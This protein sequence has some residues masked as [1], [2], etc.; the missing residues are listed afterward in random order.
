MKPKLSF[1]KLLR[2][3]FQPVLDKIADFLAARGITAN[4][5]T[6]IGLGGTIAAA[7]LI[8]LGRHFWGG[9]LLAMMAPLDAIDGTLARRTGQIGPFGAFLDSTID[10]Y[11]EWLIFGA[12]TL[13]Y[14]QNN[15][16]P[17]LIISLIALG[18]A[19]LV[20]YTRARAEALG[21]NAK[22]GVGTRVERMVIIVLG[23]LLNL[24][25][26]AVGIIAILAHATAIQRILT[27]F[28]QS[29]KRA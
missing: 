5:V 6:L 3:V 17:G 18:G 9:L 26:Y 2:E 20:S 22:V 15:N 24:A 10:R 16:Q 1:E 11:E 12:L 13:F 14:F 28:A 8:A 29:K 27:V 21:F 25:L 4:Q 23:L 7:V 19:F